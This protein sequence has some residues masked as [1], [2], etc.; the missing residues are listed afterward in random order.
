MRLGITRLDKTLPLPRYAT[1]GSA[2]FDVYARLEVTVAPK[3]IELIP[4]NLIVRIPPGH[5]LLLCS[6]SSTPLKKGLL[7]PHGLGIVDRDYRGPKDELLVQVY[8]FTDKPVTVARGDRLA[9]ALLVPVARCE[10]VEIPF[11][12]AEANRGGYGS[13]GTKV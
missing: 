10:F 9:Q 13:T 11:P 12:E 1:P 2:A 4:A 8:N 6:R 5:T 7:T 3:T